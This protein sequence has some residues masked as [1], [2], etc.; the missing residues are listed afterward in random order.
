MAKKK[1]KRFPKKELNTWLKKH[2]Q[3]NH[4]EWA[5]LIEDLSTQGFHEW[6]DTEQGRNEIGF[7][8]ETKQ[9]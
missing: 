7:Y 1:K 2:S 5:S 3:W 8:L 9:R 6:T 4:P